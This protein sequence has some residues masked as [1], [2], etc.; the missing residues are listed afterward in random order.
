M[1]TPVAPIKPLP[2]ET[3]AQ[4]E[5]S[6]TITSLGDV[7]FG[8]VQNALDGGANNIDVLVDFK[9]GGC[10]VEDD[11]LGISPDEFN[12]DG[13]LAKL[14]CTSRYNQTGQVFG[15][16]GTFLAS[17]ASLSLLTI[18]SHSHL[19]NSH[20]SLSIHHSKPISRLLPAPTHYQLSCREHG[21]KITVNN[22]FGN[23]PVR[24]KQRA[25]SLDDRLGYEGYYEV[26]NKRLVGLLLSIS[27]PVALIVRDPAGKRRFHIRGNTLTS[28]L[29]T[30][31]K[32]HDPAHI[33]V[34]NKNRVLSILSSARLIDPSEFDSWLTVS[35]RTSLL[36]V[37]GL[38]SL[39]PAPTKHTQFI[40]LGIHPID[41]T[42]SKNILFAEV[43][44]TFEASRFGVIDDEIDDKQAERRRKDRRYKQD[45]YTLKRLKGNGKGVD[46]WPMFFL[47]I[48]TRQSNPD[49]FHFDQTP[50]EQ[51][52][53]AIIELLRAVAT[54]FLEDNYFQPKRKRTQR[55]GLELT[56]SIETSEAKRQK[57]VDG[58]YS[59]TTKS[60]LISRQNRHTGSPD[61]YSRSSSLPLDFSRHSQTS[62][63][64]SF[65]SWSRI[66]VGVREGSLNA[67]S[68][69]ACK[70]QNEQ[71]AR[72]GLIHATSPIAEEAKIDAEGKQPLNDTKLVEECDKNTGDALISWTSPVT[73][74]AVLLNSRTGLVVRDNVQRPLTTPS[75]RSSFYH[76]G[77]RISLSRS[78]SEPPKTPSANFWI[79][80]FLK[81]WENPVF[82]QPELPIP[83]ISVEEAISPTPVGGCK[84]HC[85]RWTG[86][87]EWEKSFED[88]GISVSRKVSRQGLQ[89]AKIIAQVGEKFILT[90]TNAASE[91]EVTSQKSESSLL[92]LIDQHA[93]DERCRVEALFEELCCPPNDQIK[94]VRSDLN[95]ASDI[96]A[97]VLE[98]PITFKVPKREYDLLVKH[99]QYFARWG[100]LYNA[101]P[102]SLTGSKPELTSKQQQKI[103]VI[104]LPPGI[105]ERCKLEPK[106]IINL[107]RNEIWNRDT[108]NSKNLSIPLPPKPTSSATPSSPTAATSSQAS[109]PQVLPNCPQ[110]LIELLNS[111][112]CRSAIM[113]NDH[114]SIEE[115]TTLVR[116]LARCK[117][118]FMC[119]H[120]R[121]SM[122]PVVNLENV[123][124]KGLGD[125]VEGSDLGF[126]L[127]AG[128]EMIDRSPSNDGGF[129]ELCH[130]F[131]EGDENKNENENEES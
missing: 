41:L 115:C 78:S 76:G 16:N 39:E 59:S 51:F 28:D 45:G 64:D 13:G 14:Y 107:L 26:L 86:S 62:P 67:I 21:T 1:V 25:I 90:L 30:T 32:N 74:A 92:I 57:M 33:F 95:Y 105:S 6:V 71:S 42:D 104:T 44:R 83:Q 122:V 7:I 15:Q 108:N 70:S 19:Y 100:I 38:V 35:A 113:F 55:A 22:L 101:T 111:R 98:K 61:V 37:R 116:R 46:R 68:K 77:P 117:F 109:W 80:K 87:S 120:G 49:L 36:T 18:T 65:G 118:P 127:G 2:S 131:L 97:I 47:Q 73:K 66:K 52:M 126:G 130:R 8:L 112:S 58:S 3:V 12:E 84:G 29:G 99:A 40:S 53:E 103:S 110:A 93:A 69:E 50:S 34:F 119:A 82:E 27:A 125:D 124:G 121:P 114:L 88:P 94:N 81:S 17:V 72:P 11:G 9:R 128:G 89:N 123:L 56:K 91:K 75:S 85:H 31:D 79:G 96:L 4:I 60:H 54:R 102:S 63:T 48:E 106:H 10:V 20:S 5:S 43:N 24:I 129:R 23:M